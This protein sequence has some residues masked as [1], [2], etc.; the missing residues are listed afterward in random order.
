MTYPSL[1]VTGST[2][3]HSPSTTLLSPNRN[4]MHYDLTTAL[5]CTGAKQKKADSNYYGFC[6][7]IIVFYQNN[8]KS[9]IIFG[10]ALLTFLVPYWNPVT[11]LCDGTSHKKC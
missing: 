6:F 5:F 8:S 11:Y 3:T 2:L 7:N 9:H 1:S 4:C 10:V